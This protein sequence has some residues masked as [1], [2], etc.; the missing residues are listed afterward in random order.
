MEVSQTLSREKKCAA[1]SFVKG[2]RLPSGNT[3]GLCGKARSFC[4]AGLILRGK[5]RQAHSSVKTYAHATASQANPSR[6]PK[7]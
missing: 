6:Q 7:A 3:G 4:R 5:V 2:W 1:S